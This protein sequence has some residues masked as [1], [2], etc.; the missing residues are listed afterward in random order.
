M[1]ISGSRISGGFLLLSHSVLI[2]KFLNCS[3]D[4]LVTSLNQCNNM[5]IILYECDTRG[6]IPGSFPRTLPREN[7]SIFIIPGSLLG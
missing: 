3:R 6:I 1:G 2:S 4:S 7:R 5:A